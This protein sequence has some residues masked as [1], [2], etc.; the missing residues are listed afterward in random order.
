M[1]CH[2]AQ[3]LGYKVAVL[4]PTPENPA[5]M[6]AE[7]HIQAEYDDTTALRELAR[8]C[9][10]VTTEFENIPAESLRILAAHCRIS[11][12]ADA[13]AI[14]QD[15]ITEKA[16]VA[17]QGVAIAPYQTIRTI[18]DLHTAPASLF[19]G[20]LKAARFG[21]DGKGQARVDTREQALAAFA[22]FH[23][24]ACVLEACL[25]LKDEISVVLARDQTGNTAIFPIAYNVH[26]NG[27]LAT[28]VVKLMT[29][30]SD[31]ERKL[32][33]QATDVAR[34]LAHRLDYQGVLGVEFFVLHDGQLL[35]NEMAPRP[36]NSGHYTLDACVTSQ[37]EQQVRVMTGLPL[38]SPELLAPAI[39]L[40]IL[41]DA[42]YEAG[43]N[44]AREPDWSAVLAIPNAKL[45]LYGKAQARKG[46][47]MGHIT[48]IASTMEQ[49]LHDAHQIAARLNIHT[50]L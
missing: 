17:N 29:D 10:A 40:N 8:T 7:R 23:H 44:T 28:S 3:Q 32:R 33:Q 21:Y 34:H 46:R 47:K 18:D 11:P 9:R 13:V 27:I 24:V 31:S 26:H 6:V 35:V 37:F 45:H 48:L 2:A 42:W 12:A 43:S 50:T 25:S 1:F 15:R 19:P 39:M 5:A 4:D 41:G 36:H 20:I 14:M 16:F 30:C 22:K 49:A 38:G